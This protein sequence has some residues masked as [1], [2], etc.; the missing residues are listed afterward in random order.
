[1]STSDV[2]LKQLLL[3][4]VCEIGVKMPPWLLINS[5]FEM[6]LTLPWKYKSL[7]AIVNSYRDGEEDINQAKQKK[8]N[9][10]VTGSQESYKLIFLHFSLSQSREQTGGRMADAKYF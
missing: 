1:M 2:T 9:F 5:S 8:N 6:A 3:L 4:E 10:A 7:I